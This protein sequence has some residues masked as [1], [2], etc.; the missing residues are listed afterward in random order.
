MKNWIITKVGVQSLTNEVFPYE[1]IHHD[2][3]L[4]RAPGAVDQ[5]QKGRSPRLMTDVVNAPLFS[6]ISNGWIVATLW[7]SC[8]VGP[9]TATNRSP[10]AFVIS[11]AVDADSRVAVG[12]RTVHR[13]QVRCG[14]LRHDNSRCLLCAAHLPN[15]VHLRGR[16]ETGIRIPSLNAE[17]CIWGNILM[18][19]SFS[20]LCVVRTEILIVPPQC[21]QFDS[22]YE[23]MQKIENLQ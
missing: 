19:I 12:D 5:D 7:C 21:G 16:Q 13:P 22:V 1:T 8:A 20:F 18:Q 14:S 3:F 11:L 9:S 17:V 2:I 23:E 4:S 6:F 15:M 10:V